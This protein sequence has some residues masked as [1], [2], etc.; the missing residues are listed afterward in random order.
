MTDASLSDAGLSGAGDPD[1]GRRDLTSSGSGTFADTLSERVPPWAAAAI[2]AALFVILFHPIIAVRWIFYTEQP[3]YSHCMLLPLVS[4]LYI[5]ERWDDVRKIPRSI[6][7]AGLALMAFGV[8]AFMIGRPRAVNVLQHGG[9]L[10]TLFGLVWGLLGWKFF[11]AMS[12]PLGY[13]LLTQPLPKTWDDRITLPLQGFAT[14]IAE[15][16][17]DAFGWIVVRQGNVIQLPG[18]KLLVEDACSGVHS[19][20]ALV[21]LGTAWVFLVERPVWMRFV[22][23]AA[24]LPVAVAANSLRVIVTGILA[25]KVDPSYAE[26]A[27]HETAG[28]IVFA[29]GVSLLL[30]IDW[31]LKPDEVPEMLGRPAQ[32]AAPE[33]TQA[34]ADSSQPPGASG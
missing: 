31:C 29:I 28:L 2:V 4:G 32:E 15:N 17:F 20:Y 1:P 9:M 30:F 26:G 16:A 11:R 24:T 18:L 34:A 7:V 25:H 5:W 23:I 10:L 22:V 8:L 21:A 27:S 33:A 6:S 13:L 19:L 3:R 12:F 14:R